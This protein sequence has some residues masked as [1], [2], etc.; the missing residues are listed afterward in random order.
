VRRGGSGAPLAL[1]PSTPLAL[2]SA[3]LPRTPHGFTRLLLLWIGTLVLVDSGWR[4][5]A[6]PPDP[7]SGNRYERCARHGACGLLRA[8]PCGILWCQRCLR[9]FVSTHPPCTR[10]A[11][12]SPAASATG[13][14]PPLVQGRVRVGQSP[15]PE[16]GALPVHHSPPLARPQVSR[17]CAL[18]AVTDEGPEGR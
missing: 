4:L 12:W 13:A 1:N 15:P 16:A 17:A 5:P 8:V 11:A 7:P 2:R 18:A 9:R 10:C 14:L 3:I 6:F